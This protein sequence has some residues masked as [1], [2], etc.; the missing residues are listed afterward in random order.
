[1]KP[2]KIDLA[3]SE[4]LS[5]LSV[6]WAIGSEVEGAMIEAHGVP[7]YWRD[8]HAHGNTVLLADAPNQID[9]RHQ[10]GSRK[11]L[12]FVVLALIS[13]DLCHHNR[14]SSAEKAGS[15]Y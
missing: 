8:G 3:Q 14:C 15:V 12:A 4:E 2:I 5:L 10:K 7:R 13:G 1:M 6:S 11:F 9:A